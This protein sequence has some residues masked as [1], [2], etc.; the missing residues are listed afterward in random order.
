MLLFFGF[1]NGQKKDSILITFGTT[2]HGFVFAHGIT[3]TEN[4]KQDSVLKI[5]IQGDTMDAIRSLLLYCL[6]E[7]EESD[8]A[9]YVFRALNLDNLSA[10]LK[11][12][13]FDFYLKQYRTSVERNLI[14]RGLKPKKKK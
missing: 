12:E 10:F 1:C 2:T 4:K 5:I 14:K 13:D 7:K 8:Y 3:W 9:S 6:Q 11:N